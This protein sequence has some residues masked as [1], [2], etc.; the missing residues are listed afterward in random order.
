MLQGNLNAYLD[1]C[2]DF[3][4]LKSKVIVYLQVQ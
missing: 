4:Q 2:V 3:N 1:P